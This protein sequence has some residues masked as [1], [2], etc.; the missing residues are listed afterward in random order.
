[1]YVIYVN[2]W[3]GYF[4]NQESTVKQLVQHGEG[5]LL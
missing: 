3:M 4:I 1:M 2:A 5:K